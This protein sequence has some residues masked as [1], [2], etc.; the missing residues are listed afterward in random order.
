MKARKYVLPSPIRGLRPG[1]LLSIVISW[2]SRGPM[3]HNPC[4]S[5]ITTVV[6]VTLKLSSKIEVFK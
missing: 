2:F 6:F 1:M 3:V 4:S 5:P